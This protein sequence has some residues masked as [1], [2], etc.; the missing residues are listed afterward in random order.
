MIRGDF[1]FE[2]DLVS[3]SFL[4]TKQVPRYRNIFMISS[5]SNP[6]R[7]VYSVDV[8]EPCHNDGVYRLRQHNIE[9]NSECSSWDV[10]ESKNAHLKILKNRH[11]QKKNFTIP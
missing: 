11:F 2:C 5:N 1:Q 4:A 7:L 8:L 9:F 6:I 10:R 3:N